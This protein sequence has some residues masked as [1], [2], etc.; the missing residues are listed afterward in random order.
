MTAS[1]KGP[2]WK[3]QISVECAG[4]K[5]KLLRVNF[6]CVH[7]VAKLDTAPTYVS[8]KIGKSTKQSAQN[9]EAFGRA[10]I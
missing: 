5:E 2:S 7:D 1:W 8:A 6:Y 10:S 3:V 4:V 9:P